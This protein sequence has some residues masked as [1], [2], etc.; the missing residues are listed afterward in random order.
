M[1]IA[2][3]AIAVLAGWTLLVPNLFAQEKL[4][5]DSK[6]SFLVLK[7]QVTVAEQEGDKKV[8]NLPYTFFVR[9]GD[10]GSSSP[11]TKLRT[12]SRIPVAT[13][14]YH[15][16][17]SSALNV[18]YQYVDVGTSIDARATSLGDGRFDLTLTLERSWVAGNVPMQGEGQG[19]TAAEPLLSRTPIIRQ[20][21]TEF[22]NLTMKDGQTTQSTQAAD[23]VS[24]RISTITVTINVVK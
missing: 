11:W 5:S 23:P 3:Y 13:G 14:S 8:A 18:Q 15:G 10:T 19:A 4:A 17:A 9:A 6:N 16:D 22:S 21:K 7:V 2:R 12:G 20:F 1:K 24:G